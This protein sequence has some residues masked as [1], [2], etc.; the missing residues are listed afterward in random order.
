MQAKF[1][2]R[3]THALDREGAIAFYEKTP[4]GFHMV[5]EVVPRTALGPSDAALL[6]M[7]SCGACADFFSAPEK[8]PS[9]SESVTTTS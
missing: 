6:A 1:V 5:W 2:R 7:T 8:Y 3:C 9:S 4:V